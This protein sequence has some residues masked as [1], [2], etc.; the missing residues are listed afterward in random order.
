M[1]M[2]PNV[3]AA[4]P[5]LCL[6]KISS[7]QVGVAIRFRWRRMSWLLSRSPLAAA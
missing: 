1:T 6:P 2:A 3:A 7:A 4:R 5:T